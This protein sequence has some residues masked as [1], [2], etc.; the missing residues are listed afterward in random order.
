M[1][2]LEQW[3]FHRFQSRYRLQRLMFMK[4]L[5]D[6]PL[7]LSL[8]VQKRII[9]ESASQ[10]QD[11][12]FEKTYEQASLSVEYLRLCTHQFQLLEFERI[13]RNQ[14]K[15]VGSKHELFTFL[16]CRQ[17]NSVMLMKNT[18]VCKYHDG[19]LLRLTRSRKGNTR[20][21]IARHYIS[22]FLFFFEPVHTNFYLFNNPSRTIRSVYG[23]YQHHHIW[24]RN[25]DRKVTVY[26]AY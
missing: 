9:V 14:Q 22:H 6:Q 3:I 4:D 17:I 23:L 16:P 8:E 24:R 20:D 15:F 25:T 13:G 12:T 7:Q 11:Q 19:R 1:L 18:S 26:G 10:T 2:M 21:T 5:I